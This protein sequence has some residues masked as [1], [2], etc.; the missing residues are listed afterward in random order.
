MRNWGGFAVT[1]DRER[2]TITGV[3][4]EGGRGY[5]ADAGSWI[6]NPAIGQASFAAPQGSSRLRTYLVLRSERGIRLQGSEALPQFV[7]GAEQAGM[8]AEFFEGAK[9]VG[10]LASFSGAHN[11]VEHPYQQGVALIGDAAAASDPSWGQG[12]SLTLRAVRAPRDA[13]L[14]NGRRQLMPTR[15]ST[16]VTLEFCTLGRIGSHR[17]STIAATRLTRAAHARCRS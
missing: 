6:F 8:P 3:L 1:R 16:H 15:A 9:P 5:R 17:S 13:L 10:P 2:L 7:E 12:L 11:W 14:A 4:P